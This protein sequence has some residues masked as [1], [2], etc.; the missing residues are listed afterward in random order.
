MV[1]LTAQ[2][3]PESQR[4]L[5]IPY[6]KARLL[7]RIRQRSRDGSVAKLP[8]RE[9]VAELPGFSSSCKMQECKGLLT[10]FGLSFT[11]HL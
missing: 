1:Y 3:V 11:P 8:F 5:V 10:A 6:I 7:Q 9:T 4:E 2:A